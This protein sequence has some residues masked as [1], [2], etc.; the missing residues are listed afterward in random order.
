[1]AQYQITVDSQLLHQLFLGNSQDAGV[2][3]LLESVL[4]QV[5]QAQATEQ[6][7]AEP[8]ERTDERQGYRNGTYPHQLTTRV[9][10]ITLRVPR[11][12]GGKFSTELFARYQRS[13]QALVLA[14]MEMVVNGVSTRKVTQITEELCGTEFSKSTVSD[15][16][17]KLDPIVTSWNDRPLEESRYPFVVVDAMVLKVREDGRVRPRGVMIAYGVNTDG[18]REILGIMLGDSESEAS[19][20]EFFGWL[21]RR[22]L[23]GVD[24]I[25]SDHHGGL[26]RAIRQHF[27]GVMWQRCQTHFMRNILDATPKALQEEIHARLRAILDAP[28]IE[29]ARLLLN[30]M[31]EAYETKASKAM[32]ILEAGFDDATAVLLLPEKYRKRL[33]TTNGLERLNEEIRRRERVIR[34]FPNRESVLR[35]IGALLMEIDEKWASG[36]KYLDMTEYL[37][38]RETHGTK[39]SM[40]VTRIG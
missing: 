39:A 4:N 24:L 26:I 7:G 33:R 35:M 21:K 22:G 20:S 16:C 12:R 25:V 27:Q 19:W 30:Q 36:K 14:L 8:Y 10:T 29:T 18:Y 28:D 9:G 3:K 32:S 15:L 23:R 31:L 11:I 34:I 37:K 1:M 6:L 17:K 5:L 2:A 13:E 38:W 40:K